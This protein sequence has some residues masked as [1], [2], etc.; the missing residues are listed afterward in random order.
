MC[1][2]AGTPAGRGGGTLRLLLKVGALLAIA[3]AAGRARAQETAPKLTPEL[4][5]VKKG[6]ARFEDAARADMESYVAIGC[7]DYGDHP[8]QSKEDAA[9]YLNKS[10]L[11][12]MINYAAAMKGSLDPTKPAGLLYDRPADGPLKLAGAFWAMPYKDGVERPKLFGQDFRGPMV[13]K[14]LTPLV[15]LDLTQ[16]E[17]HLWLWRDNPDGL[18]A[19]SNKNVPCITD[20][21]EIRAKALP[22]PGQLAGLSRRLGSGGPRR[23]LAGASSLVGTCPTPR[24]VLLLAFAARAAAYCSIRTSASL[25]PPRPDVRNGRTS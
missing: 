21:Y 13:E 22:T 24:G 6:L 20:G 19:R 10:G 15:R 1:D 3:A 17:L 18:F 2:C 4:E 12:T 25:S 11:V 23:S 5:A 14:S 16:Y 9:N 8:E 7:I